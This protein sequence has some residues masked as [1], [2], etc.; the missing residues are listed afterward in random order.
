MKKNTNSQDTIIKQ[1]V[2]AFESKIVLLEEVR[3]EFSAL[4]VEIQLSILQ[5]S[6]HK[7][8]NQISPRVYSN[9][10]KDPFILSLSR[11]YWIKVYNEIILKADYRPDFKTQFFNEYCRQQSKVFSLAAIKKALT[12]INE[13]STASTDIEVL[14]KQVGIFDTIFSFKQKE[15]IIRTRIFG[16]G[17]TK[18]QKINVCFNMIRTFEQIASTIG[19]DIPHEDSLLKYDE[20]Q[21]DEAINYLTKDLNYNKGEF[22]HV[23]PFLQ[24][25]LAKSSTTIYVKFN[26]EVADKLNKLYGRC[27]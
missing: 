9:A 21:F 20:E 14:A 8:L 16:T 15:T 23:N 19:V 11:L 22:F 26:D 12:D 17:L 3:K 6:N 27:I 18:G 2:N 10:A 1:L 5:S 13:S 7:D 24:I 4:D 25:Q